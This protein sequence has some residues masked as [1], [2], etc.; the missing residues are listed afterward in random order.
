MQR[1]LSELTIKAF[2]TACVLSVLVACSNPKGELE[3]LGITYTQENFFDKG[4]HK[5]N[6][7]VVR[8]FLEAGLDVNASDD[9]GNTALHYAAMAGDLTQ[10]KM[11]IEEFGATV[12]PTN[13]AGADVLAA[14]LDKGIFKDFESMRETVKY[15]KQHGATLESY[16]ANATNSLVRYTGIGH[17]EIDPEI[18]DKRLER[19][20]FLLA[21]G[22]DPNARTISQKKGA[23]HGNSYLTDAARKKN[24]ALMNMLIEHGADVNYQNRARS[25]A[26]S[27][28]KDTALHLILNQFH[29]SSGFCRGCDEKYWQENREKLNKKSLEA[30]VTIEKLIANGADLAIKNNKGETPLESF[31]ASGNLKRS[32]WIKTLIEPVLDAGADIN[33]RNRSG[34]TLLAKVLQDMRS[35]DSK[36]IETVV[37][38]LKA[39]GAKT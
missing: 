32:V 26:Y 6:Q 13:K 22:Y 3:A 20:A 25:I 12:T 8:L 10:M 31:S 14:Y 15:L 5:N 39:N 30:R 9:K 11:L 38:Y 27:L 19:L 16:A 4:I 34:K 29:R 17:D 1:K 28:G 7:K 18:T 36:N 21:E 2:F 37:A 24:Y 23:Y 35:Q 33:S